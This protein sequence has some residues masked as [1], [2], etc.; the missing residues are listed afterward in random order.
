MWVGDIRQRENPE[1][2]GR[3]ERASSQA[4]WNPKSM[5][6]Q[7]GEITLAGTCGRPQL[8]SVESLSG[9]SIGKMVVHGLRKAPE[10][11]KWSQGY[12]TL[13]KRLAEKGSM[14]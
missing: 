11:C 10:G 5:H 3:P 13:Q 9:R 7:D 14:S 8:D 1:S 4:K 2:H 12:P 6:G